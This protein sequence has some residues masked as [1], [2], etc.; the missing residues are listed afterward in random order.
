ML[1]REDYMNICCVYTEARQPVYIVLWVSVL[2]MTWC[3]WILTL[4]LL[5]FHRQVDLNTKNVFGQPRLRASLR[6]LR[7][8]RKNYKSTIEDDLKRLIIMDNLGPEQEQDCMVRWQLSVS[9][10]I[11]ALTPSAL[12]FVVPV[13]CLILCV[14][15]FVVDLPSF[16]YTGLFTTPFFSTEQS[17]L[18]VLLCRLSLLSLLPLLGLFTVSQTFLIAFLFSYF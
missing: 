11:T 3:L 17:F 5:S 10:N 12:P 16:T 6:D 2:R 7:S 9:R 13:I 4:S 18:L 8:P 15:S 14:G 1:E